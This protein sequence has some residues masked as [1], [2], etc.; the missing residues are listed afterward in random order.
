MKSWK[1]TIDKKFV[2]QTFSS[3][4]IQEREWETNSFRLLFYSRKVAK[5]Q[6]QIKNECPLGFCNVREIPQEI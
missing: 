2:S 5:R 3:V 6:K 4:V 1:R